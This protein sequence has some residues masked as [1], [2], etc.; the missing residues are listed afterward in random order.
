MLLYQFP[1]LYFVLYFLLAAL[2]NELLY[3]VYDSLIHARLLIE[4]ETMEL[5]SRSMQIPPYSNLN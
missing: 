4:F 3:N 5:Q 2:P 1:F